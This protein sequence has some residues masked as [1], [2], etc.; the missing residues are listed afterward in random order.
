MERYTLGIESKVKELRE[1][2]YSGYILKTC[3]LMILVAVVGGVEETET[4]ERGRDR[5]RR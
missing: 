5:I 2:S 4:E 3:W 1:I